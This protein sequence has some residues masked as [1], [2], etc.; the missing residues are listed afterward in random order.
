MRTVD[1]LMTVIPHSS[2]VKI[3][4]HMYRVDGYSFEEAESVVYTIDEN[5][6]DQ[7][8]YW[9]DDEET[10]QELGNAEFYKIELIK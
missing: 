5:S 1:Q 8:V 4:G 3:D 6:G 7:M 10:V 9:L 2:F